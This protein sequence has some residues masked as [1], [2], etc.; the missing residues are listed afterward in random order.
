MKTLFVFLSSVGLLLAA[1]ALFAQQTEPRNAFAHSPQARAVSTVQETQVTPK[2]D[3]EMPEAV[4]FLNL[5][6]EEMAKY[7]HAHKRF[8][9]QWHQLGFDYAYPYYHKTDPGLRATP[10]DKNRWKPRGGSYT[11]VIAAAGRDSF[12]I[13]ALDNR[14]K[15][16]YELKQG[17]VYPK[18]VGGATGQPRPGK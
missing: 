11:Y 3:V 1:R 5:A 6:G 12:L 13:K 4:T 17:M 15:S 10:G 16:V 8:A 7:R 18:P 9:T 14:G 2:G